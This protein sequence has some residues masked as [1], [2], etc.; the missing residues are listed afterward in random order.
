MPAYFEAPDT[1]VCAAVRGLLPNV[2]TGDE[3]EAGCQKQ[4]VRDHE[5]VV[6]QTK[7]CLI[8]FSRFLIETKNYINLL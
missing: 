5:R 7:K 4:R 1:M 8:S 2:L 3:L 6:T